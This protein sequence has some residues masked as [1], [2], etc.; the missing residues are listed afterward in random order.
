VT[1]AVAYTLDSLPLLSWRLHATYYQRRFR[2][3]TTHAAPAASILRRYLPRR[4]FLASRWAPAPRHYN[5]HHTNAT[6]FSN[7][8]S[9]R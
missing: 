7:A 1:L 9:L 2:A 8:T 4:K 5:A 3:S 6:P